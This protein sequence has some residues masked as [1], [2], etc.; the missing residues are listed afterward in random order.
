MKF[1]T[2]L[3]L[4]L[5]IVGGALYGRF[6][7]LR[8]KGF[9]DPGAS[10]AAYLLGCAE[11]PAAPAEPATPAAPK[12][13]EAPPKPAP[14]AKPRPPAKPA[15]KP[16]AK[17]ERKA[18]APRARIA[19]AIA[20]GKYGDALELLAGHGTPEALALRRDALALLE[21]VKGV[22]PDPAAR[23][24][25][26]KE[27]T[28]ANGGSLYVT[29]AE[30]VGGV[31]QFTLDK[32]GRS[33]LPAAEV[34]SVKRADPAVFR[35]ARKNELAGYLKQ[36]R[37]EGVLRGMKA[38]RV[39][40]RR[41]FPDVAYGEY[42]GIA[43]SPRLMEALAALLPIE[44]PPR[45]V[46][47]VPIESPAPEKSKDA[48][49]PVAPP[50]RKTAPPVAVATETPSTAPGARPFA[51]VDERIKEAQKLIHAALNAEGREADEALQ[52]AGRLLAACKRDM[53]AD[54]SLPR[55]PEFDGRHAKITLILHDVLKMSG[56]GL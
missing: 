20:A 16:P 54:A 47:S 38:I 4:C 12:T 25:D 32:G 44:E 36:L 51:A 2:F 50:P 52:A 45:E 55:G 40:W 24:G 19:A 31:W 18:A 23:G 56:F 27:I 46:A 14:P 13:D 3:L 15:A 17:A 11:P 22:E 34:A 53:E 28:L 21:I 41:G 33:E 6:Q 49:A 39:A 35:A 7:Y 48:P 9:V 30:Q 5:A 37:G 43:A 42:Q 8:E 26:V 29:A 1:R 10:F